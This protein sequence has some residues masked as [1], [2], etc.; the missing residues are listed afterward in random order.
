VFQFKKKFETFLRASRE[1]SGS[2]PDTLDELA[3]QAGIHGVIAPGDNLTGGVFTP[4]RVALLA[5]RRL[6]RMTTARPYVW[7]VS[8]YRADQ[9][10]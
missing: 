10:Q 7:H 5:G 8:D 4:W 2:F 1:S 6:T 9:E 3:A